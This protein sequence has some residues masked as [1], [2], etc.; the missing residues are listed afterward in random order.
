MRTLG[1]SREQSNAATV[2]ALLLVAEAMNHGVDKIKHPAVSTADE[3]LAG[4]SLRELVRGIAAEPGRET[5]FPTTLLV[6][7]LIAAGAGPTIIRSIR[8]ARGSAH[9]ASARFHRRYGW[10]IDP[11]HWRQRHAQ[12]REALA[13]RTPAPA[14]APAA[15]PAESRALEPQHVP[16]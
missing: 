5:P 6:V 14:P 4:A 3:V 11:G 10:L 12:L 9:G 13:A 1:V 15:V 8:G 7:A 16:A 2:I